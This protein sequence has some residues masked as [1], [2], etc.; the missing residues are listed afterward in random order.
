MELKKSLNFSFFGLK[1]RSELE[2]SVIE[3][4]NSINKTALSHY[5]NYILSEAATNAAKANLKKAYMEDKKININDDLEYQKA[6]EEFK[7]VL[8]KEP[9]K[10]EDTSRIKGFFIKIEIYLDGDKL[11]FFVINNSPLLEKEKKRI[12]EKYVAARKFKSVEDAMMNAYDASEGAGFGLIISLLMLRKIDLDDTYLKFFS[13]STKTV[14]RLSIP[15]SVLTEEEK[16]FLSDSIKKEIEFIP[17]FPENIIRLQKIL[18]DPESDFKD[19]F[20]I[21][22][23]DPALVADLLRVVNSAAYGFSKEI[24]TVEDAVKMIGF[25]G[26]K[27]L[28]L[29]YTTKNILMSHYKL[30]E[31]RDIMDHSNEV[32]IIAGI[33]I[34][35][36]GIRNIVEEFYISSLLHDIGKIIVFAVDPSFFK[37]IQKFAESKGLKPELIDNILIGYNHSVIGEILAKKWNFPDFVIEAIRYHHLPTEASEKNIELV[38]TIYLSNIIYYYKRSEYSFEDIN[39]QV[40]KRFNINKKEEMDNLVKYIYEAMRNK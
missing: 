5:I 28:V 33:I 9:Q 35:K 16:D 32:A 4:L 27:N 18:D 12:L 26:I 30:K 21:I 39:I 19:V 36:F 1:E 22:K 23:Q 14:F 40:L 2:D 29:G 37:K 6:L 34:S 8:D 7:K 31:V 13:D 10:L 15:I 25:R 24:K 3:V 17:Q 38:F 20:V 11:V